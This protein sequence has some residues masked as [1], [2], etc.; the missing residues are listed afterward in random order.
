[1]ISV[2]IAPPTVAIARISVQHM[3]SDW[4]VDVS[5]GIHVFVADTS[6]LTEEAYGSPKINWLKSSDGCT[7]AIMYTV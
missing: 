3:C 4:E 6:Y 5:I 1:M 2:D 7:Y